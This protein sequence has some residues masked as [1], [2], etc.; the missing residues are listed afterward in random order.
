MPEPAVGTG[1]R[2]TLDLSGVEIPADK[3]VDGVEAFLDL[4]K[5]VAR[6]VSG[7]PGSIRWVISV[8][9]GSAL[10]DFEPR[11]KTVSLSDIPVIVD[12]VE[13]GIVATEKGA[14]QPP[15]FSDRAVGYAGDL[16]AILGGRERDLDRVRVWRNATAHDVTLRTV[17]NADALSGIEFRDWGTVEG[18][19]EV[20]S[21]RRGLE[22]SVKDAVTGR[23]AKCYFAQ[24]MLDDVTGAFMRRVSVSGVIR[25]RRNGEPVSIKVEDFVVFPRGEELP[26]FEE[27][28]GIL[29]EAS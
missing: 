29:G 19:L 15:G 26:D 27:V 8:R 12:A 3:F 17:A 18:V 16:A 10:I 7:K 2:L 21:G 14:G 24:D 11:P 13:N 20:I 22:F 28:R 23:S 5:E 1:Q 4:L 9:P 6:T 25:Y